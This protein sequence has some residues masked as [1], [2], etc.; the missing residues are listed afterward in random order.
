MNQTAYEMVTLTF[1]TNVSEMENE[2][3]PADSKGSTSEMIPKW[4][5]N[6]SFK[7]TFI[8]EIVNLYWPKV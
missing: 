4:I 3:N 8:E 5:S 7:E 6:L 1:N 2:Y